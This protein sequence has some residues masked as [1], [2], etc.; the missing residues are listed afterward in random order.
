[1]L[2]R[3]PIGICPNGEDLLMSW[4]TK[5][6]VALSWIA[7]ALSGC[8][9]PH[10]ADVERFNR[11]ALLLLED[12]QLAGALGVFKES[13]KLHPEN[14][15]TLYY[16]GH[17]YRRL[18]RQKLNEQDRVAAESCIDKAMYFFH[19][20]LHANPGYENSIEAAEEAAMMKQTLATGDLLAPAWPGPSAPDAGAPLPESRPADPDDPE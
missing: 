7:L 16:I 5:T 18:A 19:A 13:L 17:A 4:R 6:T 14:E 8:H 20:S 9:D 11:Q 3:S 1:M 15:A 2:Y 10:Q 12:G